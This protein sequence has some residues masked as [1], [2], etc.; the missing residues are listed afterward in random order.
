MFLLI[1]YQKTFKEEKGNIQDPDPGIGI[2]RVGIEEDLGV[3]IEK[4]AE[5]V[6]PVVGPTEDIEENVT[7]QS[8]DQ[9]K[10][11]VEKRKEEVLTK[12]TKRVLARN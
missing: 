1:F 7:D 4:E 8:Q 3:E 10:T 5:T 9:T 6:S 11:D 2:K 12:R